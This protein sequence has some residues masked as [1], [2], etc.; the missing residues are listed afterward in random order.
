M[1]VYRIMTNTCL[2]IDDRHFLAPFSGT[3]P[4]GDRL[5]AHLPEWSNWRA[6]GSKSFLGLPFIREEL[7]KSLYWSQLIR[8]QARGLIVF[9]IGGST[10]GGEMLV[11]TLAKDGLPVQFIDNLDPDRLAPIALIDWREH[12]LLVISKSGET[13][14]TLGQ[15]LTTLPDLEAQ[16]GPALNRHVAVITGNP[17]STLGRIAQELEL[18]I[19]S[20]PE[21]GGRYAVLSVVGLLPAAV[22][23]ADCAALLAGAAA[24]ADL[25]LTEDA[26][27]PVWRM[28]IAQYHLARAGHSI[29]VQF[30]YGHRLHRFPAWF[31]QLCAESLGKT[32][33]HGQ[34]RGLTPMAA[35]GATD[36]HSLLQ[37]FLDGPADKQFTFLHDSN[38]SHHGRPIPPRFLAGGDLAYLTGHTT[39]AILQAECL[40]AAASLIQRGAPVRIL[41][42]T[43]NPAKALGELIM[44]MQLETVLLAALMA[45]N[46]FDQPGVELCKHLTR[47]RLAQ[48]E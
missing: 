42:L 48:Q 32:N 41:R 14:E 30:A 36:Q 9:G 19:I 15:L 45:I 33:A 1:N 34:R 29:A 5:R 16:L 44:L 37:L 28:T 8:N 23:G 22:A 25:G 39:G 26:A 40:S 20:H 43:E 4:P 38:S 18:P 24:M 17:H 47:Q 10:L 11:T 12:F 27:N 6:S 46:P 31:S 13:I 7:E 3:D 2:S 21:V 35:Q